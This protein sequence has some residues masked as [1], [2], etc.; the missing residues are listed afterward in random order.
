MYWSLCSQL[1]IPKVNSG[2]WFFSTVKFFSKKIKTWEI[3]TI[4]LFAL[5]FYEV[6]FDSTS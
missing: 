5:N 4:R 6:A 3:K 1:D 2:A